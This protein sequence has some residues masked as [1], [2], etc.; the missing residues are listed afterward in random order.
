MPSCAPTTVGS[1]KN[2]ARLTRE[3]LIGAGIL[4]LVNNISD[5]IAELDYCAEVG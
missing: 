3:R 1:S 2:T 5:V 4:P